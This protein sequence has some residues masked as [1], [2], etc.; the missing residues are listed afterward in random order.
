[1][2]ANAQMQAKAADEVREAGKR[3]REKAA[4]RG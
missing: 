1:M 2:T 3:L 4:K